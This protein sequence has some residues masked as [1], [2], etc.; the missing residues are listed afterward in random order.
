MIRQ[1]NL[2]KCMELSYSS[3]EMHKTVVDVDG[4]NKEDS[5]EVREKR[6]AITTVYS[7]YLMTFLP[8]P[9]SPPAA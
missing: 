2:A 8:G 7:D 1:R 6:Q 3:I 5:G 9:G 4:L